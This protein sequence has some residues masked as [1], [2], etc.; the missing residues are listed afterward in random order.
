L[1]TPLASIDRWEP[2]VNEATEE[3]AFLRSRCDLLD[4][5]VGYVVERHLHETATSPRCQ[6]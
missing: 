6:S 3:R 2:A 1:S 4:P 5:L